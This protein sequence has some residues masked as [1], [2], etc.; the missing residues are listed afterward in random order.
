[1]EY[2]IVMA[3]DNKIAYFVAEVNKK[4]AEGWKPLGGVTVAVEV[5]GKKVIMQAMVKESKQ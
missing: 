2:Q 3:D 1:M 4:I 5:H